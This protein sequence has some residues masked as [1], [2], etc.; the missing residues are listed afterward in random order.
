MAT[1]KCPD[2]DKEL[3]GD[4]CMC[5]YKAITAPVKKNQS[6][7]N[8]GG[9]GLLSAELDGR[10]ATFRCTCENGNQRDS[11]IAVLNS[12]RKDSGWKAVGRK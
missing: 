12:R 9:F 4:T 2:C 5:G 8:C 10:V 3:R 7:A 1:S 6:C 11:R